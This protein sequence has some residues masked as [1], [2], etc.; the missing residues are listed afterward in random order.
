[1]KKG[2]KNANGL[3][4][5]K[6]KL[7]LIMALICIV[8]LISTIIVS[9]ISSKGVSQENAESLNLKQA[10][11]VEND[12]IKTIDA[13]FRAMEQTAGALSTREFIKD[14]ENQEKFDAMVKQLQLVD[15]KF[16][17]GNSTVVTG[18][19][20]GNLARSKGDFT[21][22]AE[23]EYF[24]KAING[25][26]YLSDVSVSKTTGARIIVPAVP[27]FDDD[28]ATPIG[29]LSRNYNVDYL[30]DII[31][32]EASA[33]QTVYILDRNGD[34]IAMSDRELTPED[35]INRSSGRSF[36]AAAAGSAEGSFIEET[37]GTKF[38]TSYV[39]EPLTG[40]VIVVSTQYNVIMARA[41]RAMV[42]M[43]VI[44][45]ILAVIA[46]CIAI[47]V[48]NS[49]N[50]PITAIDESLE[51][52][53]DGQ[54][55]DITSHKGR[56]DEFGTMIRNTNTVI[57]ALDEILMGINGLAKDVDAHA[58]EVE[59]MSEKIFG[60][61]EGASGAISEIASGAA[62]QAEDIQSATENVGS[63][64]DAIQMV[65]DNAR[66]LK[67]TAGN[68][69]SNSNT[70]AEQLS[71][72]SAASDGMSLSV[73][74]IARSIGATSDA[75]ERINSK[76]ASITEIASQTNLLSLNA[77]I[78]A[79]RAG[80]AGRGFAVVA[81]EIGKLAV[82]SAR[83]AEE[84]SAEMNTL[85]AESQGAVKK[86]EEVMKATDDQK[87]V[88]NSTVESI[89]N[90]IVDIETTVAGVDSITAAAQSC[91][92]AKT[93]VVDAMSGLSAISQ[94]N[95]AASQ[96]T[97]HSM[98]ELNENLKILEKS[99]VIMKEIADDMEKRLTFFKLE[100]R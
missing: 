47:I 92:D 64:S 95:A 54:F 55:K 39:S 90:L 16:A 8:P 9:Y 60:N 69:H 58:I 86:S 22:I 98:G 83:A 3:S 76:V 2:N 28:G 57:N 59:Q 7:I 11:F 66:T 19:D 99:A 53:A 61:A 49:I 100:N 14:H 6:T 84:I 32:S 79:A 62:Q 38:V 15:E 87:T 48:G 4:S 37:D 18:P 21:N 23:R 94:E 44:G 81:E 56:R 27:V 82:D 10:E 75:V 35:Q 17:D 72:L 71:K 65:L 97:A 50:K 89:N 77:S 5:M 80:E 24:K 42:I 63:I 45:A 73:N 67:E 52:L 51:L 25:T 96:E 36:T 30:H 93:V 78:E 70:S 85:L 26:T 40:W 20:G 13:N 34:V 91:D 41:H 74:Q 31:A 33:G 29:I 46:V 68:M 1:M 43:I 88:L 12:F